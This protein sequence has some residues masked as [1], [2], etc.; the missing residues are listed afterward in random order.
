VLV[1]L[2]RPGSFVSPY[3]L[4]RSLALGALAPVRAACLLWWVCQLA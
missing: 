4:S 3:S 2:P 1:L